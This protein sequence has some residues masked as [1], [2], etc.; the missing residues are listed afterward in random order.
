MAPLSR[1]LTPGRK[2]DVCSAAQAAPGR[3]RPSPRGCPHGALSAV[4]KARTVRSAGAV[5]QVRTG[6]SS[7]RGGRAPSGPRGYRART[8]GALAP[9]TAGALTEA[10]SRMEGQAAAA[11][12]PREGL[13]RRCTQQ[14]RPQCPKSQG[15]WRPRSR[16]T[17]A[18]NGQV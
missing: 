1:T 14:A 7:G 3:L 8:G 15:P 9:T 13:E 17:P 5:K 16:T 6:P 10:P 4:L 12:R 11:Q 18:P 2:A